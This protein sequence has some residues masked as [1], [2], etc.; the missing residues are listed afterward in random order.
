MATR[1]LTNVTAMPSVFRGRATSNPPVVTVILIMNKLNFVPCC[2]PK[3]P[4]QKF[5]WRSPQL[6]GMEASTGLWCSSEPCV[7]QF[8]SPAKPSLEK[9]V[10]PFQAGEFKQLTSGSKPTEAGC[11]PGRKEMG[12]RSQISPPQRQRARTAAAPLPVMKLAA[13]CPSD[14]RQGLL[15]THLGANRRCREHINF[16]GPSHH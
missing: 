1:S 13:G 16:C 3:S 2:S 8:S 10:S 4:L 14:T 11:V 7:S 12:L 15:C 9:Q 5:L 6:G